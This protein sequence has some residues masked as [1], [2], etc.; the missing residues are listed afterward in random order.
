M[1]NANIASPNIP[2]III[3]ITNT[4]TATMLIMNAFSH[5]QSKKC[6]IKPSQRIKIIIEAI[7]PEKN[8]LKT[9]PITVPRTTIHKASINL[10]LLAPTRSLPAIQ[11]TGVNTKTLTIMLTNK[12]SRFNVI[13]KS[14]YWF[15]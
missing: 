1:V 4:T 14:F 12:I 6:L 10:A 15:F 2:R 8:A 9:P 5:P 13:V 7:I 3:S 11:S